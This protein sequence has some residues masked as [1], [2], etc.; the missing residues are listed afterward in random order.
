MRKA[1]IFLSPKYTATGNS[2]VRSVLGLVSGPL[3][4]LVSVL[5]RIAC[6]ASAVLVSCFIS[7]LLAASL[8]SVLLAA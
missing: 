2:W 6:F 8:V 3:A 1:F 4:C 5:L 7:A